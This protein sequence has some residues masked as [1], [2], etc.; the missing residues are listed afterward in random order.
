[1]KKSILILAALVVVGF[2]SC[3]KDRSCDC[4]FTSG[5]FSSTETIT[6]KH[7]TKKQALYGKCAS[8]SQSSTNGGTTT[9]G[10]VTCTLK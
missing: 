8:G 9:T 7:V 4:T 3:K 5:S 1:M 10:T 2:S 6:V